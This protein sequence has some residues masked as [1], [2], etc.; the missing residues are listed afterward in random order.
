MAQKTTQ[1]ATVK[2]K[3]KTAKRRERRAKRRQKSAVSGSTSTS[4]EFVSV[5]GWNALWYDYQ[6]DGDTS[7]NVFAMVTPNAPFTLGQV[8][9]YM[10]PI[11]TGTIY[12]HAVV[13]MEST[14]NDLQYMTE[15]QAAT[16]LLDA[17]PSRVVSVI[18]GNVSGPDGVKGFTYATELDVE[19]STDGS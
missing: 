19:V 2:I 7:L 8:S 10:A 17:N 1:E 18:S 15:I 4:G 16:E 14:Q 3:E 12:A 5:D 11:D 6:Y 13:N 9:L